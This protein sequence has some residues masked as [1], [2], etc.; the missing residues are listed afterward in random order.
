MLFASNAF[1]EKIQAVPDTVSLD[2]LKRH[3]PHLALQD[4]F[5]RHF[6]RRG[7]LWQA[8][9]NFVE[10]CAAYSVVCYLLQVRTGALKR[11]WMDESSLDVL[12][13][14]L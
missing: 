2:A 5:L 14:L 6:G 8:R 4:F 13:V 10:S 7:T 12:L 1:Y 9:A 3:A 11:V